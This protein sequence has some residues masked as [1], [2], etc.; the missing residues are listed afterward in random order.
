MWHAANV[1]IACSAADATS[2][3]PAAADAGFNLVTNVPAGVETASAESDSRTVCDVA[4][5]CA[6]GGPVS[7]NKI[8]R[9]GPS[10]AIFAPEA[11]ATYALEQRVAAIYTCS[12]FG[13]SGVNS[14]MGP[15]PLAG[16]VDTSI[17]GA[18]QFT[19]N[20]VD[21]VGNRATATVVYNVRFGVRTFYDIDRA[22]KSGSTIPIKIQ[23]ID[24]LGNNLSSPFL[25]VH[26]M[27]FYRV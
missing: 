11:S 4:G 3:L 22:H 10:I 23:L 5:N 12:D 18:R 15:V 19:V 6:T 16:L 21:A 20:A 7:G 24:G 17:P 13:G 9:K 27:G 1:S 8:D 25:T 26:E 2:G 14:C